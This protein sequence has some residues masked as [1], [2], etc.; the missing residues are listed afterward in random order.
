MTMLVQQALKEVA[1]VTAVE[2]K[3]K[4]QGEY[5]WRDPSWLIHGQ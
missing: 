1:K 4:A 5:G 2:A 3:T